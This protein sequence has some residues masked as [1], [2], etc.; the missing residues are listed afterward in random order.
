M[1]SS[2]SLSRLSNSYRQIH[3]RN[4][5]L[6]QINVTVLLRTAMPPYFYNN[7]ASRLLFVYAVHAAIYTAV[8]GADA[9]PVIGEPCLEPPAP[10]SGQQPLP[11]NCRHPDENKNSPSE[12]TCFTFKVDDGDNPRDICVKAME[13]TGVAAGHYCIDTGSSF[14]PGF[15]EVKDGRARMARQC[16]TGHWVS[17]RRSGFE[18]SLTWR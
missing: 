16:R 6:A 8:Q 17:S 4:T 14:R 18:L 9:N 1:V 11:R 12:M 3:F 10:P 15:W 2:F 7:I 13:P 5:T